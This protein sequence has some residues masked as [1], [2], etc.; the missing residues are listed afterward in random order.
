M[1]KTIS[2]KDLRRSLIHHLDISLAL[3]N[4]TGDDVDITIEKHSHKRT[5]LQNN[6]LQQ[7]A[8]MISEQ[9]NAHNK[10]W[11]SG[12]TY[13]KENA[14]RIF[15]SNTI[16]ERIDGKKIVKIANDLSKENSDSLLD[17]IDAIKNTKRNQIN[18]YSWSRSDILREIWQP[19]QDYLYDIG[20]VSSREHRKLKTDEMNTVYL[21]ASERIMNFLG[22]SID[23]PVF[24]TKEVLSANEF[25]NNFL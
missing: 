25:K 7:W 24:G 6:S 9:L 13:R 19:E 14:P 2:K 1:K 23:Y 20:R 18:V 10:R 4:I 12:G 11:N 16:I 15:F 22:D 17:F 3:D 5:V 8:R 21:V